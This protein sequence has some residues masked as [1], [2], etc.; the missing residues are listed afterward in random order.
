M[1]LKCS[2]LD[3]MFAKLGRDPKPNGIDRHRVPHFEGEDKF[4][5]AYLY[6]AF[7]TEYAGAYGIRC[8]ASYFV[9][10]TPGH[11]DIIVTDLDIE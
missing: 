10:D 7:Y 3:I 8:S 2:D 11:R 5:L 9:E 1:L 6:S 4:D